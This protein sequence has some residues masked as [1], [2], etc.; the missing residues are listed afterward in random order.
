LTTAAGAH[1]Q[2]TDRNIA[3][4]VHNIARQPQR[5]LIDGQVVAARWDA[6]TRALQVPVQWRK[7]NQ[8]QLV[9]KIL[10]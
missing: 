2:A 6:K 4:L 10:M 9:V 7:Q 8:K 5:V 3:L 1:Y